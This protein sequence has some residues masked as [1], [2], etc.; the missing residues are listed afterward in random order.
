MLKQTHLP[1][2]QSVRPSLWLYAMTNRCKASQ[3]EIPV[4]RLSPAKKSHNVNLLLAGCWGRGSTWLASLGHPCPTAQPVCQECHYPEPNQHQATRSVL[5]P[6]AHAAG[7]LLNR[8][9]ADFSRL[10]AQSRTPQTT[11]TP[12]FEPIPLTLGLLIIRN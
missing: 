3:E 5:P 12:Q 4:A 1:R 6:P 7:L 10:T 8:E 11:L 2:Q 9:L